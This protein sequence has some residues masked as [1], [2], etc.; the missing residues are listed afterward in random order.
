MPTYEELYAF[1]KARYKHERFAGRDSQDWGGNV[2]YSETVTWGRLKHLERFGFDLISRHE[3]ATGEGV[4]YNANL[5]IIAS[6]FA[7]QQEG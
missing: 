1:L 6:P 5:E 4:Y 3:S 2:P 7:R